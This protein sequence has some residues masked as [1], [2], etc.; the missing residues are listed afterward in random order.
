M[1]TNKLIPVVKILF[2]FVSFALNAQVKDTFLV[3]PYLQ[4]ATQTGISVLWETNQAST[5]RVEYA[6]A[7]L[8]ADSLVFDQISVSDVVKNLHEIRLDKLE[9]NTKY[10]YRVVGKLPSGIELISDV[11]T[12]KTAIRSGDSFKFVL[13]GDTQ[14]NGRT[15][16][17]WGK[18]AERAWEVRPDFLV[19]AGDL[20]DQGNRKTDWT[21]DFF[22]NGNIVMKRYPI[23]SVLGNHE[24]DSH[25]YY[26][27]MVNP[28]PEYYYTFTYGNAQFFM[29]DTNRDVDEDSEQYN[30][31][32]WELSKSTAKWKFVMH[33]HPPYTSDSDDHGNTYT[34]L[35]T[36]GG[37][38]ARNLVP[39]M[40]KY[41]VDFCM[42]GHTHLYERTF[43]LL[44]N[45]VNMKNGVV[46]INSGGAGGGLE[47]FDPVRN[48][49]SAELK[50]IH[51]FCTFTVFNDQIEFKAIDHDGRVFDQY[52]FNKN[53]DKLS[54]SVPPAPRLECETPVFS[55]KTLV[56]MRAIDDQMKI[57]YTLDGSEPNLESPLYSQTLELGQ[58]CLVRAAAFDSNGTMSRVVQAKLKKMEPKPA[59]KLKKPGKGVTYKYYEGKWRSLPDFSKTPV[60]KTGSSALISLDQVDH[61]PDQ[62]AVVFE[63]FL[64]VDQTDSYTFYTYSDDGSRL[65]IDDEL[66][67]DADGNHSMSYYYG[68]TILS[69]GF[70][71]IRV[72]YFEASGSE[73][74]TVGRLLNGERIPVKPFQLFTDN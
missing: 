59:M 62:F 71:K 42:F 21:E 45:K 34:G 22:P 46:Y 4:Y 67:V 51:H 3:K 28:E 58:S 25:H 27:Y 6:K 38:K 35:S 36:G 29:I 47:D 61:R 56:Q 66:I 17:A 70:H 53:E 15:P 13:I 65:Y 50:S 68:A 8:D 63:G 23:Y 40:E 33:H 11:S 49:F 44:D 26:E 73:G 30:W 57:R 31:L 10:I 41:G 20:V 1:F 69:K 64:D 12:F 74:I 19:L 39:L 18:V 24:Q 32:E 52:L 60:V 48:W 2:L 43:P 7:K 9:V 14:R 37:S 5:G 16:W 55:E 54:V 72:E